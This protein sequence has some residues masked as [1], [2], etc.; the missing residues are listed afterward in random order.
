[1]KGIELFENE[2][3]TNYDDFVLTWIPHYQ[4]IMNLLP[5]LL[6]DANNTG[7]NR[8]LV[9]GC[10]TGNEILAFHRSGL[11]W[12]ITGVDPSPDMIVQAKKKIANQRN[13]ELI[14]GLVSDLATNKLYGAATLIL[15]LHF[16]PDDGAKQSLLEDI[17]S[18]LEPGAPFV[19]MDIFGSGPQI[20][21]NLNIFRKTL[22]A[23]LTSEK[24]NERLER[25]EQH[26]HY[27][28]EERLIGLLGAAGF[29]NPVRFHQSTIYGGWV[30]KKV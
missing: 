28:P 21:Q 3:A 13:I 14:C 25:I 12:S 11:E 8:L 16:F 29:E 2:R 24:I 20:R 26:I 17:S 22:P 6:K 10:G 23:D 5:V 9:A 19:L 30:T 18:R 4:F 15:V 27:I 7:N 1:M